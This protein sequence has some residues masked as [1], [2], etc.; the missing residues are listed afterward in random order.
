[1]FTRHPGL[2]A[3]VLVGLFFLMS[4]KARNLLSKTVKHVWNMFSLLNFAGLCGFFPSL[5][6]EPLNSGDDVSDE[7]DNELFDTENV[8]VCQYDKVRDDLSPCTS[9]STV[10]IE[11][12][13]I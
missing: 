10:A 5:C 11:C 12:M 7:E 8:V 1:M 2:S 6:Q 13:R 3:I 4:Y 9:S